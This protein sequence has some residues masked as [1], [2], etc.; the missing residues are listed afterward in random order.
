MMRTRWRFDTYSLRRQVFALTGK[1][2]IF[3]PDGR[4][5]CYSEQ[6]MFRWCE[7]IRVYENVEKR[8]KLL[9]IQA[10]QILD[11]SASYDVFDNRTTM[12]IGTL[13]RR[14]FQSMLREQWEVLTPS[15]DLLATMEEDDGCR[16]ALRRFLLGS[17]L[18]QTYLIRL[19]D[20][21]VAVTLTQRFHLFRYDMDIT[22]H[23]VPQRFDRRLG[24]CAAILLAIIE[25]KQSSD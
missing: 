14:G 7:D 3:M 8:S 1:V 22:F 2:R 25:G 11:F 21:T 5:C 24:L 6:R 12:N 16:A 18:P 4:L 20:G 9:M 23:V 15:G 10:R 17:L 13:R 19:T